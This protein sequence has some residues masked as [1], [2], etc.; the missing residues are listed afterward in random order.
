MYKTAK[1]IMKRLSAAYA[2]R[3]ESNILRLLDSY[4]SI[5]KDSDISMN[6]H[7]ALLDNKR[8]ELISLGEA[9]SD[10]MSWVILLRSLPPEYDSVR[11]N[12]ENVIPKDRSTDLLES[13]LFKKELDLTSQ[14]TRMK[15]FNVRKPRLSKEELEKLKQ[16]SYCGKCGKKGHWR[17]ECPDHEDNKHAE[18]AMFHFN[19][20]NIGAHLK[21][22]WLVLYSRGSK[23]E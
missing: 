11:E 7:V 8:L 20:G 13:R 3:S 21:T 19:M 10:K 1:D 22:M 6:K 5:R 23:P 12:W 2:D 16:N 15:T 18:R 14:E 4:P 9:I 17:K